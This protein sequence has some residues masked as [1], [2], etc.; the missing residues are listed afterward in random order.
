METQARYILVG[1]FTLAAMAALLGFL[2]WLA[3]VEINRFYAQYDIVFDTVSGLSQD[4]VVRYNGVDV[5]KVLS[6]DLD[7]QNPQF[8]RVRIEISAATPVR[9]DTVATL[10]SQGVTGVSFVA[11]EGGSPMSDPLQAIPPAPVPVIA[12]KPSVVQELTDAAPD[13]LK[14][15]IA[16]IEDIRKFT[17][18][19]NRE[20]IAAILKN[21]ES[22]TD[23]VDSLATRAER[24]V[25]AAETTLGRADAALTEAEAA[26]A[27]AD[28]VIKND[29]PGLVEGLKA[30]V[31]DVGDTA[32]ELKAFARSALPQYRDLA[33]DAR[34]VIASIGAVAD[35]I[36]R[37]P[38][39]FLLGTQTPEYRN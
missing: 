3:Q 23:R 32:E 39:R 22:V 26:F 35:R 2:L 21:V 30:T 12:S 17:T 1:S 5:G 14:E 7:R 4:S 13:L 11:L 27:S 37:D 20:A 25:I 10:S 33:A 19:E 34:K 38:S 15:A 31:A 24:L 29:I 9:K 36:G 8:V 28:G 18:P 6:I 16:L